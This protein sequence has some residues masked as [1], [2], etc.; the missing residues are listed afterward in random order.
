MM[1]LSGH[2]RCYGVSVSAGFGCSVFTQALISK[3]SKL[4]WENV[5]RG[6][7]NGIPQTFGPKLFQEGR[8]GFLQTQIDAALVSVIKY[9]YCWEC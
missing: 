6:C 2:R 1:V 3:L 7:G 8:F 5:P 4:Y 9:S